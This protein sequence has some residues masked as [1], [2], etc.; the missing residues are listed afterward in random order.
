MKK[1][2]DE[3]AGTFL[4]LRRKTGFQKQMRPFSSYVEL[5]E[6]IEAYE[7]ELKKASS[8]HAPLDAVSLLT[9]HA[10]K[11]LEFDTVYIPDCNEGVIPHKKSGRG[12]QVEE[13]R[14]MLYVAMTRARKELTISWVAGTEEEP[15]FLSR[16]LNDMGL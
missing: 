5:E 11:G 7:R 10:S 15:G 12:E 4:V 8:G 14:R 3:N 13:E 6:A 9:M 1:W 2:E 16:F